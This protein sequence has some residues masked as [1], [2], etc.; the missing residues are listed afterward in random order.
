MRRKRLHDA[1]TGLPNR[2]WFVERLGD[3]LLRAKQAHT[4]TAVCVLDVDRFKLINDGYGRE[5]GDRLLAAVG[6]R[7]QRAVRPADVVAR[8]GEDEFALLFED[9][10]R[11]DEAVVAARRVEDA[12]RP[13]LHVDGDEQHLS[14]SIGIACG[15]EGFQAEELIRDADSA[16]RRAKELG[17]GRLEVY[18]QDLRERS[19]SRLMVER[20]LRVAIREG[21]L[22]SVY[23]PIVSLVEGRIVGFESLVRWEHPVEGTLPPERFIAVAEDSGLIVPIGQ[24]VLERACRQAALWHDGESGPRRVYVNVSPRQLTDPDFLD[25]LTDAVRANDLEPGSLC[26][27]ITETALMDD[28]GSVPGVLDAVRELGVRVVLDDFGTGCSSLTH[29][30]RVPIDEIKIDRFFVERLDSRRDAAAIVTAVMALARELGVDAVAEGVE[31]EEELA[32]LRAIGCDLAQGFR[33][34]RPMAAEAVGDVLAR[35]AHGELLVAAA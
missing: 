15:G 35:E 29:L 24:I 16:M 32:K 23:Q 34:A 14:A 8:F 33:F 13:P 28:T 31:T 19:L 18:E 12:L 30:S 3:S 25:V 17:R 1:L 4:M 6:D 9:L 11:E 22:H 27:E 21:R 26:I 7:L 10:G 5:V 20:G 2:D